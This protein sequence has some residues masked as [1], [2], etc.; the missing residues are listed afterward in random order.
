MT[1]KRQVNIRTPARACSTLLYQANDSR[2]LVVS[3]C[4][5]EQWRTSSVSGHQMAQ[6]YRK[7]FD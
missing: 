7:T 3:M 2:R 1:V 6:P 4:G 5:R